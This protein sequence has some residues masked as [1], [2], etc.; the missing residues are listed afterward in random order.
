M[1]LFF[2]INVSQK[3]GFLNRGCVRMHKYLFNILRHKRLL[4][5]T[6]QLY[7][8]IVMLQF[9]HLEDI[10]QPILHAKISML[11]TR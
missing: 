3:H 7:G 6:T 5:D 2:R 1:S 4:Y 9:C 11:N 10:V 8:Y